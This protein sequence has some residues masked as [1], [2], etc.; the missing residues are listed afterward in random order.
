MIKTICCA[1]NARRKEII[2]RSAESDSN[3]GRFNS[4]N[5]ISGHIKNRRFDGSRRSLKAFM[6]VLVCGV[7]LLRYSDTRRDYPGNRRSRRLE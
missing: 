7:F 5:G 2:T 3:G 4:L 6:I 1:T